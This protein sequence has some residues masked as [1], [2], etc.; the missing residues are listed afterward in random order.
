MVRFGKE[1]V[2]TSGIKHDAKLFVFLD[3]EKD[4]DR[5]FSVTVESNHSRLTGLMQ[6][7]TVSRGASHQSGISDRPDKT[8]LSTKEFSL[9][10][11]YE[12]KSGATFQTTD[13]INRCRPGTR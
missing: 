8:Q 10:R 6:K 11:V 9:L 3:N 4:A 12:A 2:D 13:G 5:G 1:H 7:C